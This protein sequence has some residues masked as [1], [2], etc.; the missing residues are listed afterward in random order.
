MGVEDHEVWT[1]CQDCAAFL[2]G[3]NED[4]TA[5]LLFG[6]CATES[7]FQYRRQKGFNPNSA[8]GAFGL[9]QMEWL[10]FEWIYRR[11]AKNEA[12]LRGATEWLHEDSS[13]EDIYP[14]G[15]QPQEYRRILQ[16]PGSGD[17]L[18]CLYARLCYWY[19]TAMPIP[20]SL[21]HQAQ[22]YKRW[23]NGNGKGTPEKY[24]RDWER[25]CVPVLA[26]ADAGE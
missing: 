10:T 9:W 26:P 4:A 7:A 13:C 8:G 23:Y 2:P 11:L 12:L 16:M 6:T 24:I 5:R 1:L 21:L 25:L 22:Y 18:A 17:R 3:V 14:F 19:K 15:M 20:T